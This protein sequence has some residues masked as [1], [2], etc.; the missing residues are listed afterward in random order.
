MVQ[1]TI[2]TD[3]DAAVNRTALLVKSIMA[4]YMNI[5]FMLWYQCSC[6]CSCIC[7]C[8][9]SCTVLSVVEVCSL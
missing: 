9:C 4:Q 5:F 7:S 6:I 3:V 8:S 1:S 2:T